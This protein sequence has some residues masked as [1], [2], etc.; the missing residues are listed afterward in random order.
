MN[1]LVFSSL[2][3]AVVAVGMSA[4]TS[5]ARYETA[6]NVD[7][8]QGLIEY[9][10]ACNGGAAFFQGM[11]GAAGGIAGGAVTG[12]HPSG[13]IGGAGAG[14]FMGEQLHQHLHNMPDA[15]PFDDQR[16]LGAQMHFLE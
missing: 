16:P 13:V 8:L 1:S 6:G 4:A 7:D 15:E 11:G 3:A 9:D 2:V 12:G 5:I 14:A 10:C